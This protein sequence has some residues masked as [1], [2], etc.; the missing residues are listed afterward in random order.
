MYFYYRCCPL[1]KSHRGAARLQG[2]SLDFPVKCCLLYYL[3]SYLA[4][5]DQHFSISN[6]AISTKPLQ[7]VMVQDTTSSSDI[8]LGSCV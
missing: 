1:L 6:R 7:P 4:S 5:D 3:I 2:M 8:H